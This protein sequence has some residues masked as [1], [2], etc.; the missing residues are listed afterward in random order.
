M[1]RDQF[2][3]LGEF[4]HLQVTHFLEFKDLSLWDLV[5]TFGNF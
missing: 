3:F 5:G 4:N 1:L 2:I